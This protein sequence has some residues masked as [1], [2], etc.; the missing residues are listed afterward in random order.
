MAHCQLRNCLRLLFTATVVTAKALQ[1]LIRLEV[2]DV[3]GPKRVQ[4]HF[5]IGYCADIKSIGA[6]RIV[7]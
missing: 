1:C 3:L 2:R 7:Q 4:Y 6:A 5:E